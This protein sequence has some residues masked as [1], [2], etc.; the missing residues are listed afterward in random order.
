M[1]IEIPG[2]DVQKGLHLFEDDEEIYLKVLQSYASSTPET[3]E[4]LRNLSAE[5][6]PKYAIKIHGLKGTSANIG[7]MDMNQ[8][9]KEMEVFAKAGDLD[10]LIAK[11]G[12]FVKEVEEL[13]QNINDWLKKNVT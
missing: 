11:N 6:L 4:V 10:T 13:L 12:A 8:K 5:T 3:V 7:A 2:V 1:T 9:A